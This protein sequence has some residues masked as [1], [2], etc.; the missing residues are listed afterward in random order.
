M[1]ANMGS[2]CSGA[3]K[4]Q[5]A[6]QICGPRSNGLLENRRRSRSRT[7]VLWDCFTLCNRYNSCERTR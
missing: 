2:Y 5:L 3:E 6:R 4:M 7:F 1:E